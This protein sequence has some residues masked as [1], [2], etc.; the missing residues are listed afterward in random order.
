MPSISS[1][2]NL[3][4]TF[5]I[6]YFFNLSSNYDVTLTPS[7]QSKADDYYSINYRHLTK[8][9]QFN[10]DSSISNDESNTGTKNHVFINGEVKNLSLIHI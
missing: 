5:S 6:P 1:D 9:H 4:T 10:I 7:I 8:N 2:N 3:G